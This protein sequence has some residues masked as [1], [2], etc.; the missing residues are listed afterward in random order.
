MH[1]NIGINYSNINLCSIYLKWVSFSLSR[2]LGCQ[3]PL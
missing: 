2:M 1:V 3:S